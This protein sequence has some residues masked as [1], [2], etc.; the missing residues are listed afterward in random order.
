MSLGSEMYYDLLA[1]NAYYEYRAER[2]LDNKT[3]ITKDG[4]EIPVREMTDGHLAN[5]IRM[6]LRGGSGCF[7]GAEGD[8]LEMLTDEAARRGLAVER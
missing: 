2:A 8:A 5:C 6:M 1:D 7:Y 4:R 3:W